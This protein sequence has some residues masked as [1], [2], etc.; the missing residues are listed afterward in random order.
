[1]LKSEVLLEAGTR[2]EFMSALVLLPVEI[3]FVLWGVGL[4]TL[5]HLNEPETVLYSTVE[6][7]DSTV[8]FFIS[9]VTFFGDCVVELIIGID[10]VNVKL[11]F[12]S[13]I[14]IVLDCALVCSVLLNRGDV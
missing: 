9:K 10:V 8:I 3:S 4:V 14:F 13:V 1:V 12:V 2:V 6:F 7:F 5:S 11:K